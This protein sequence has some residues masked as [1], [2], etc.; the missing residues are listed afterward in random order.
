M[1][2]PKQVFT[3]EHLRLIIEHAPIGIVIIDKN[4][5]WLL[6]NKRFSEITGYSADELLSKTFLD[7]TYKEDVANNLD[8]YGQMTSGKVNEYSYEKR[9]VRKNGRIVWV[10]LTVAGVRLQG[11][12]SH[13]IALIQDIDEERKHKHDLEF[14]NKELDTLFYK[15]S[16][17]LK[18]PVATL[19]GLCNILK[20]AISEP[21]EALEHLADT[22][23]KLKTQN[24][25]LLQLAQINEQ[26]IGI[27]S[28][29]FESIVKSSLSGIESLLEVKIYADSTEI[30]TD[31]FLLRMILYNLFHNTIH[32]ATERPLV[33]IRLYST[34]GIYQITYRDFGPGI[35]KEM[36]TRVF[37]MFFKGSEKSKGSGLGLYIVKKAIEKLEGDIEIGISEGVGCI[38]NITLPRD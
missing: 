12:Y 24:A 38:F 13:M 20:S 19:E 11:E 15:V 5:K 27:T 37:E 4:L 29:N 34:D 1:E 22:V 7:I 18:A 32:F 9:Y 14:R 21:R 10:R 30:N 2:L 6:T 3:L 28:S 17:D 36:K 26:T 23:L 8:L 35:E 33:E 25:L 16:H 31:F